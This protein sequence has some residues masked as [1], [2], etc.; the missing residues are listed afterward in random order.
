MKKE[1][2]YSVYN[3]DDDSSMGIPVSECC[4]AD[5]QDKYSIWLS[6]GYYGVTFC[7]HL[8]FK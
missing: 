5:L 1:V 4:C 2:N 3:V 8:V 7:V 6:F